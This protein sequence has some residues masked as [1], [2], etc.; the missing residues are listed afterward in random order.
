MSVLD[1]FRDAEQRV[2]ARLK[3][4][5]PAIAEFR[6]LEEVARRL[7]IDP[8]AT[9]TPT[10]NC[11]GPGARGR[12]GVPRARPATSW[13]PLRPSAGRAALRDP[14]NVGSSRSTSFAHVRG[15][16]FAR[17]RPNGGSTPPACTASCSA[18]RSG[19]TAQARAQA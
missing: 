8:S 12:A 16:R 13:R 9:A 15:S 6:E 5:E 17:R 19:R 2:A 7:R 10:A 4:R 14:V 3:E 11:A 1:Q 18:S